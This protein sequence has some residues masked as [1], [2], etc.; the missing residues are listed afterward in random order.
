MRILE[1]MLIGTL[2]H[3]M[4]AASTWEYEDSDLN[5]SALEGIIIY[6]VERY[7][8]TISP[9]AAGES[10]ITFD[11]ISLDPDIVITEPWHVP[12]S[13]DTIHY[14]RLIVDTPAGGINPMILEEGSAVTEFPEGVLTIRDL[15]HIFFADH[16]TARFVQRY[17]YK[18]VQLSEA[19][20]VTQVAM[21]R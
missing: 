11:A 5:L 8:C 19:E 3:Q 20:I 9:P 15:R 14:Y 17:W 16:V 4:L 1:P 7:Q 12:F 13:K 10:F 2:F 18:R 6:K 21:R